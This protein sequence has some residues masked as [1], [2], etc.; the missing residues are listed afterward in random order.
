VD[1]A[2]RKLHEIFLTFPGQLR[3]VYRILD[4]NSQ[5]ESMQVLCF[6][7]GSLSSGNRGPRRVQ[8]FRKS[9]WPA[10]ALSDNH[11]ARRYGVEGM[12]YASAPI[13]S[14]FFLV[15]LPLGL[16]AQSGNS[17]NSREIFTISVAEPTS[18]KDVQVRYFFAG[19]FGSHRASV[20]DQIAGNKIAIRS[21]TGEETAKDFKAIVYAPGCQFATISI[22]GLSSNSRQSQFQCQ[23]LETVEL[24]GRIALSRFADRELEIKALY[25]CAWASRFF[26]VPGA[27]LSPFSVGQAHVEADGSFAMELPDFAAD[28]L[29]PSL[30]H[31]ATL[32]FFL[33]DARSGERL[34]TLRPPTDPAKA[35]VMRVAASYP[36]GE[37]AIEAP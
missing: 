25:V 32:V 5:R 12:V 13:L 37:F 7:P 9:S 6:L 4:I 15:F 11:S 23:N 18:A 1:Y 10:A 17:N 35:G 8:R 27:A 2:R 31:D 33:V 36:E 34:A 16:S 21:R 24:R 14:R 20:A 28:P 19:E 26:D 29:W 22:D 30:S 3:F